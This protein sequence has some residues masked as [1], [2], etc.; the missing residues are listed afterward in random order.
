MST[1][2][3]SIMSC[4]SSCCTGKNSN[5]NIWVLISV[6]WNCLLARISLRRR[7]CVNWN[8]HFKIRRYECRFTINPFFTRHLRLSSKRSS[9]VAPINSK[10][11]LFIIF[12]WR[13]TSRFHNFKSNYFILWLMRDARLIKLKIRVSWLHRP[14]WL[15]R[16]IISSSVLSGRSS[17]TTSSALFRGVRII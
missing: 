17:S 2:A 6:R 8:W 10:I 4:W 1:C 11:N 13:P 9:S 16:M 15:Y 12:W 14:T 7:S 3:L 5:S